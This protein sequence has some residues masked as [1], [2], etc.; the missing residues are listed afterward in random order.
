MCLS[1]ASSLFPSR[2]QKV[3]VLMVAHR[4]TMQKLFVLANLENY[5]RQRKKIKIDLMDGQQQVPA[6][7]RR[8]RTFPAGKIIITQPPRNSIRAGAGALR[9]ESRFP[10][11]CKA[12]DA[13]DGPCQARVLR[14]H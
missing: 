14:A 8:P 12:A 6:I 11:A 4:P 2:V 1:E 5:T 9:G 3:R 13:S 7:C 10:L